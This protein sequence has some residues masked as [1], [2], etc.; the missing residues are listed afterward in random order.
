MRRRNGGGI[1]RGRGRERER[2]AGVPCTDAPC[3]PN[4]G[5]HTLSQCRTS[6]STRLGTMSVQEAHREGTAA[7]AME[8]PDIA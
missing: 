7:C 8:T 6:H 1:E 5:R 3:P 4:L 2:P